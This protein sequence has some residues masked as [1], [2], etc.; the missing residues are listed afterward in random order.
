MPLDRVL[1]D[2]LDSLAAMAEGRR[3]QIETTIG[4]PLP[5][6][7]GDRQRLQEAIRHLLHNAIKFNRIGG[8][9]AINC[10]IEGSEIAIHISDTGVG[11]PADRLDD[12]WSGFK[13]TPWQK[14]TSVSGL[15]LG[16]PLARFIVLSHGGRITAASEYGRGSTFSLYLP[17][18]L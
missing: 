17:I 18:V 16:L 10:R 8:Q 14:T 1:R 2:T 12:I 9:V 15:Q 7:R 6:I 11:I 4:A 3:V 13:H 5:A